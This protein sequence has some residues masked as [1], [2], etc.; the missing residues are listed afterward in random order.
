MHGLLIESR[1]WQSL[2]H[3]VRHTW[4]VCSDLA[5]PG[6][7]LLAEQWCSVLL[8][9]AFPPILYIPNSSILLSFST[10]NLANFHFLSVLV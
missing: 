5:R 2:V 6:E 10:G 4:S 8:A 3:V 1:Q 7:A 9:E